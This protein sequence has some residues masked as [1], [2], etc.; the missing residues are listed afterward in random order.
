MFAAKTVRVEKRDNK[1]L[2]EVV[3]I[4]NDAYQKRV[5]V[6][7][8]ID[9]Q[10]NQ[11]IPKNKLAPVS[12]KAWINYDQSGNVVQKVNTDPTTC[13]LSL[14]EAMELFSLNKDALELNIRPIENPKLKRLKQLR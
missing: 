10:E 1:V 12:A 3:D 7:K 14:A 5:T 13:R 2:C 9:E 8:Q 4:D 11:P 6:L